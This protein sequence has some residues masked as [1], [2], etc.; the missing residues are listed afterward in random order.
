MAP[1]YLMLAGFGLPASVTGLR[2]LN[3]LLTS[4][5]VP[6]G[7]IAAR[8]IW[9]EKSGVPVAVAALLALVPEVMFDGVRVSN[10]GL[11]ITLFSALA[12]LFMSVEDGWPGSALWS[13]VVTGLGLLT[14]AFFLMAVP[15]F[16]PCQEHSYVLTISS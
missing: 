16:A 9:R 10:S 1:V 3:L 5:I 4:A 11:T 7:F 2:L 13:G 6:A 15:V 8:S 12:A 14:K